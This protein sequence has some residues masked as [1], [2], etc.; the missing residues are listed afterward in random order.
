MNRIDI[1]RTSASRPDLLERTTESLIKNIKYSGELRFILHEDVICKKR[2][3]KCLEYAKDT[4]YEIVKMDNPPVGQGNSLDWLLKQ[5]DTEFVLNWEDDFE[6]VRELNLDKVVDLMNHGCN[7]NQI[8][9]NKRATMA[10]KPDFKKKQIWIANDVLTT[11]PHWAL[12]PALWR[13]SYIMPKWF[14]FK[15]GHHWDLNNRLKGQENNHCANWVIENTGTYYMG[16]IGEEAYSK[17][18]GFERSLRQMEEQKKWE[19]SNE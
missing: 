7:I 19:K 9:F 12:I 4:C 5:T 10:E 13:M 3:N 11:N 2:S 17:H 6:L 1:I 8:C 16:G 18:L 15:Q 14:P